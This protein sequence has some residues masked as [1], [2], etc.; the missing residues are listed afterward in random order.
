MSIAQFPKI[1]NETDRYNHSF[2]FIYATWNSY[3]NGFFRRWANILPRPPLVCV[4]FSPRK[5]HVWFSN[6]S[7][8]DIYPELIFGKPKSSRIKGTH[9]DWSHT[10]LQCHITVSNSWNRQNG[11]SHSAQWAKMWKKYNFKCVFGWFHDYLKD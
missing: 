11:P 6:F 8:R 4:I 7:L 3:F 2:V 10:G 5:A 9:W 1:P